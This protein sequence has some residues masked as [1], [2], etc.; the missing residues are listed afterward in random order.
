MSDRMYHPNGPPDPNDK[1]YQ[2]YLENV[3]TFVH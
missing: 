1:M 2:M 3:R